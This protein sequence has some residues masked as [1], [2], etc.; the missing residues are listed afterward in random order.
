VCLDI[1]AG[2]IG[3]Y[4]LGR[5]C[6]VHTLPYRCADAPSPLEKRGFTGPRPL[7][8][9]TRFRTPEWQPDRDNATG[10]IGLYPRSGVH[11]FRCPVSTS[12]CPEKRATSPIGAIRAQRG[13]RRT[14]GR[15]SG[16]ALVTESVI[17]CPVPGR[18]SRGSRENGRSSDPLA[19]VGR[20][21]SGERGRNRRRGAVFLVSLSR[22]ARGCC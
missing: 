15:R 19:E 17:Y 13:H 20:R 3:S 22:S 8:S 11:T 16:V 14:A 6:G 4:L 18:L 12:V 7:V 1:I 21:A 2:A 10:D 5:V 9:C